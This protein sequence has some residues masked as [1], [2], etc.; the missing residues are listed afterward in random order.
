MAL[1]VF[2]ISSLNCLC[3]VSC[4]SLHFLICS[5]NNFLPCLVSLICICCYQFSSL[6]ELKREGIIAA[7]LCRSHDFLAF[8]FAFNQ[9]SLLNWGI[10]AF[11][12][13]SKIF[14]NS[15]QKLI[16]FLV[17]LNDSACFITENIAYLQYYI[18]L[19][20]ICHVYKECLYTAMVLII[21]LTNALRSCSLVH[22]FLV[23][24]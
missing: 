6:F 23:L 21:V 22:N 5:F 20:I 2:S 9:L 19:S 14:F 16:R 17:Y 12:S 7:W 24:I 13:Y 8:S 1:W 18:L 4:P 10:V 11:W 15:F 3:S